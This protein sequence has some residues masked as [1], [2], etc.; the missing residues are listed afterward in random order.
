MIR[1]LCAHL[2]PRRLYITVAK[3]LEREEDL[4]F[5]QQLVQT[6]NWI[7]LTAAET[8]SLRED[9]LKTE[10]EVAEGTSGQPSQESALVGEALFVKLL[11]PW[12]HNPVSAL[13]LCLWAQ[14]YELAAELTGRLAVL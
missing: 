14:Q 8:K 9:L 2:D 4:E 3:M 12:F 13:A 5:A 6:F 1:Q 11:V 7:L 10:P